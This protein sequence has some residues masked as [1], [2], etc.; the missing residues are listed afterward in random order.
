MQT[1]NTNI[2]SLNAQ[3]NLGN[4]ANTLNT[5]LQRLSS[6][7]RINSAKD[8]AAGLAISERFSSQIRGMDQARRNAND[9]VSLAQ[10]GEGAL[11]QMGD[12]LQRIRELAVQSANATNSSS[13]RQALN[14]EVNELVAEL[15]RFATTTEFNGL[16]MFDGSFSSSI[17]QVGANANQN[18]TATTRNLRTDQ[19]GTYQVGNSSRASGSDK[20]AAYD[21]SGTGHISGGT[22]LTAGTFELRGFAGAATISGVTGDTAASLA[23][24][25]NAVTDST[26]V[27]ATAKTTASFK[28]SGDTAGSGAYSLEVL[29]NQAKEQVASVSFTISKNENGTLNLQEAVTAFNDKSSLTGI[30]A[31]LSDSREE[32]VLENATGGNIT[33]KLT[34]LS[35]A[36]V[37]SGGYISSG[38]TFVADGEVIDTAE[39]ARTYGGQLT[40]NSTSSFSVESDA[41]LELNLGAI[42][43]DDTQ[44]LQAS[45]VLASDLE[46]VSEINIST[47]E[48]ATQ[49][50][51]TV[52]GAIAAITAQRAKFG[53]LQSRFEATISNLQTS[54]ENLSAARSRIRD[55]D[56]ASETANL[57]KAQILQ[58]AG[59]AMLAQA[60]A[61]PQQVLSLLN[62]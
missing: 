29:G 16:K 44:G 37:I 36:Q 62:G 21:L 60:N 4:T 23:T 42:D 20:V 31:K 54:S 56:F 28:F 51:R 41:T 55:A 38:G 7:L 46:E 33:V 53:A 8:D 34:S 50:L 52:D 15:D 6:G 39:D 1:I 32:L 43:D 11:Q 12:I 61:L 2:P 3:R 49:A 24:K 48:G 10:T 47:V 9:G 13:D 59:T 22:V 17:F 35:A 26:G 45:T 27:T 25:I 5:S 14:S 18:I 57:T 30:T 40:L 19:Y 58:Q